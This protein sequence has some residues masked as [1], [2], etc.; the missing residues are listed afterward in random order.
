MPNDTQ[1]YGTPIK[2]SKT[3]QSHETSTWRRGV[4]AKKEGGEENKLKYSHSRN[5]VLS[6]SQKEE[7]YCDEHKRLADLVYLVEKARDIESKSRSKKRHDN[8]QSS[9]LRS[10][11]G[12][13][14]SGDQVRVEKKPK[15]PDRRINSSR[16]TRSAERVGSH[17]TYI[18]AM[19][20]LSREVTEHAY[21]TVP[22][23]PNTSG[24][25]NTIHDTHL[26]NQ[27]QNQNQNQNANNYSHPVYSIPS[28]TSPPP[29][30][31]VAINKSWQNGLPPSYEDYLCHKYAMLVR[32][33]T[34]PPP[35]SDSTATNDTA[36]PFAYPNAFL[37]K[38][39]GSQQPCGG[40]TG[41]C[42]LHTNGA[43]DH[44]GFSTRAMKKHVKQQKLR[45]ISP[46]SLSESRAQQQRLATMY[47]DGAFCME[48][49][50]I[51]SAFENGVAFCSIM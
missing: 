51:Q 45:A 1:Q 25:M 7:A 13:S 15:K 17:Y 48:T 4:S 2:P 6:P 31:D 37:L 47:E 49:T 40:L 50:A 33:H 26:L 16:R 11:T 14:S 30:Y 21:E 38:S 28:M 18:D 35:W 23:I 34:P 3:N 39:I 27:N 36:I 5:H 10:D 19:S 8:G 20:S 22:E 43:N 46:R 41:N 42:S 9:K 12:C 32:S 24:N 44:T 29:T